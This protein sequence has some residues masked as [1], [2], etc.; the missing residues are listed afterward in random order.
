MTVA[1]TLAIRRA[2]EAR[3]ETIT[4]RMAAR[5]EAYM[6]TIEAELLK[7]STARRR[8]TSID[9]GSRD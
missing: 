8:A 9:G 2:N 7:Q 3:T 5:R 1:R 6:N 4:A